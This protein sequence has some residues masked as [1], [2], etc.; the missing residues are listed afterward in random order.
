LELTAPNVPNAIDAL[1][2]G[3]ANL[4]DN[5]VPFLVFIPNTTTT[6]NISGQ[7]I[8]SQG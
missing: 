7:V 6:S 8:W 2:A 3:F 1:T 4:F 5:S